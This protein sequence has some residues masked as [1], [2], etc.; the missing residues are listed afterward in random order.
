MGRFLPK[1]PRAWKLVLVEVGLGALLDSALGGMTIELIRLIG[2]LGGLAER[3]E[4]EVDAGLTSSI[5]DGAGLA[6][7]GGSRK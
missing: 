6:G 5:R 2:S 3:T 7:A 1:R 4:R